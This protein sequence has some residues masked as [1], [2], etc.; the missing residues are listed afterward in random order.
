[1]LN[2]NL[3]LR[4]LCVSGL[5]IWICFSSAFAQQLPQ[6]SQYRSNLFLLNPAI[7]GTK[8]TV[9]ARLASRIQWSGFEGAPQTSSVSFHSRFFKGTMGAGG[10]VEQDKIGPLVRNNMNLAYAYHLRFPDVELSLGLAGGLTQLGVDGT[11]MTLY[12]VDDPAVDQTLSTKT[13]TGN[14]SAGIY[15]YNDRFSFGLSGLNY[16]QSKAQVFPIEKSDTVHSGIFKYAPHVN[17]IVGYNYAYHEDFLFE[18]TF[19]A[20]YVAATP[21]VFDYTLLLHYKNLVFLGSSL[22][23]RDAIVAHV[24]FTFFERLKLTY[25]Y[26]FITSKLQSYS[27]GSHEV[28]LVFSHSIHTTKNRFA[29]QRYGY[30][31]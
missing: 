26:D 23:I 29:N 4:H 28:M 30:M 19:Y 5:S 31:F 21:L 20:N 25:S 11:Q 18:N 24:G 8:L 17:M 12:N 7:A 9:D 14:V 16:L 22:R 2:K 13:I 15:L 3:L 6:Y 1:M 10:Y 27:K